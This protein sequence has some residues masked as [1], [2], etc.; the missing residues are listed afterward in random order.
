MVRIYDGA[1]ID[2]A[3][4]RMMPVPDVIKLDY[5]EVKVPKDTIEVDL[6]DAGIMGD[7]IAKDNVFSGK[8]PKQSANFFRLE[9]TAEDRLG[10]KNKYNLPKTFLIY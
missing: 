8:V 2:A 9:V 5:M 7:K 10:N 6:N 1:E 4:A 3:R